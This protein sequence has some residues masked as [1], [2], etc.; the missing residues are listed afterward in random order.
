MYFW[1]FEEEVVGV[2]FSGWSGF[3]WWEYGLFV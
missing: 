2:E 3:T 1:V